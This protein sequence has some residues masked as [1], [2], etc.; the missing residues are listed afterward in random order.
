[1]TFMGDVVPQ[2]H[3]G[4]WGATEFLLLPPKVCWNP[5]TNFRDRISGGLGGIS[6]AGIPISGNVWTGAIAALTRGPILGSLFD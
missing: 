1:M 3:L 5:P 4:S 2:L 6:T